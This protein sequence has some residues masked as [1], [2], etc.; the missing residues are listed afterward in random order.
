MERDG[1]G[2]KPRVESDRKTKEATRMTSYS[3]LL[4]S[5][6]HSFASFHSSH[7]CRRR[8][9]VTPEP[10]DSRRDE[11][12]DGTGR[13]TIMTAPILDSWPVPCLSALSV[14][15]LRPSLA[16]LTPLHSPHGSFRP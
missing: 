9:E 1:G 11:W 12:S 13:E 14:V 3:R 15:S 10:T 8:R 7:S 5:L 6:R 16:S 2:E 4:P